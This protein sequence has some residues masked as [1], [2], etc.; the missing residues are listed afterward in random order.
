[1]PRDTSKKTPST[2]RKNKTTSTPYG[3]ES[4]KKS[5]RK[6]KKSRRQ[7]EAEESQAA[8]SIQQM[9]SDNIQS[10]RDEMPSC[11]NTVGLNIEDH[12]VELNEIQAIATP[13]HA[14][15]SSGVMMNNN[16]LTPRQHGSADMNDMPLNLSVGVMHA[17]MSNGHI[18][19]QAMFQ[20]PS[21]SSGQSLMV[22]NADVGSNAAGQSSA[23]QTIGIGQAMQGTQQQPAVQNIG[24]G[25]AVQG[26]QQ[27]QPTMEQ[28]I[29]LQ[30]SLVELKSMIASN[31]NNSQSSDS[32][33]VNVPRS[34]QSNSAPF[35][36]QAIQQ[37]VVDIV[38]ETSQASTSRSTGTYIEVGR[39]IDFKVTDKIRNQIWS[40]EYIDLSILLEHK[41][42]SD[43]TLKLI[44]SDDDSIRL[45]RQKGKQ[46]IT[47]IGMWCDA[48]LVYLT[49]YTRK[50]PEEIASL[51]TYM[52]HIKRLF[53]RGGDFI[54]YD[55]EFRY[56]R[57]RGVVTWEI[58]HDLWMESRE[59]KNPK[60]KQTSNNRNSQ[61][62]FRSFPPPAGGSY[63]VSHPSGFCFRFHTFGNCN[64]KGCAFKHLCYNANCGF[65]HPVYM[66]QKN[67]QKGDK[68]NNQTMS[69]QSNNNTNKVK[70]T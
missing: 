60:G 17:P 52:H 37:H 16:T 45:S 2:P 59:N 54:Y 22:M 51:T 29:D 65:R 55:E 33:N 47:S 5:V 31:N 14:V 58:N 9:V 50:Y 1:M 64:N 43:E 20:Q 34:N 53:A 48:F 7:L 46:K 23:G 56:L 11:S 26:T 62:S 66:C 38:G 30:K 44:E 39:P 15:G 10:I 61:Q 32:A 40:N 57:Q 36:D 18:T 41:S 8:D 69:P 21:T 4:R 67:A 19:G 27:Q 63:K 6:T 12:Q 70:S 24:I 68:R 13:S 42:E 35:V 28:F 49:V 3:V 25:Q